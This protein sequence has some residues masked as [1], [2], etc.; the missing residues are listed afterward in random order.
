MKKKINI[1]SVRNDKTFSEGFDEFLRYCKI[2]SLREASIE[3]YLDTI[4]YTWYK[5]YSEDNLIKNIDEKVMDDFVLF[6]KTNTK[7]QD[8]SISSHL[9]RMRTIL[10]YFMK[11]GYMEK[12]VIK[13]I[14]TNKN[15]I[16]TYTDSEIQILLKK[17]DLKNV[18]L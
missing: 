16:E 12:F 13:N 8:S 17:P 7:Q 9:K 11:L 6:L 18:P 1:N 14:K 15:L 3:S 2:R 10:N 4:K 5:F